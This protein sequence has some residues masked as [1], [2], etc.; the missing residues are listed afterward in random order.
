MK[1]LRRIAGVLIALAMLIPFSSDIKLMS[2][3]IIASAKS[4]DSSNSETTTPSSTEA[5]PAEDAKANFTF[6]DEFRAVTITPGKDF[7]KDPNQ[8]VQTTQAEIDK[9]ISNVNAY[10]MTSIIINTSY[11]NNAYFSSGAELN[12][13]EQAMKM[14]IDSAKKSLLFVYVNLNMNFVLNQLDK[15]ADLQSRVDYLTHIAHKFSREYFIDGIILDGYYSS[16]TISS[17]NSYVENGSGIGFEN[18]LL[19]NGAYVFG[20]VS[21]AIHKTDNKIPVGIC[22]SNAWA[23]SSENQTGSNTKDNFQALKDGFSDTV[24]YIKNGYADFIIVNAFGSLTDTNLPFKEFVEWWSKQAVE[25][26]V[27]LFVSH[28]NE[29]LCTSAQGWISEDQILKQLLAIEKLPNYKGSAFNS[30]SSLAANTVTTNA[31]IKYYDKQINVD[32]IFKELNINS[33]TKTVFTTYEPTVKFQGS[34]DS[35]F[36]VYFNNQP[37]KLNEAGNFYYEVPLNVGLNVFTIRNKATTATYKITRQVKVLQSIQPTGTL[38]VDGGN[39]INVSAIAYK[40]ANITATLNGTTIK[41]TQADGQVEGIDPNSNY[42]LFSGSFKAPK[43]QVNKDQNLGNIIIKGNYQG[44]S[45]GSATGANVIVNKLPEGSLPTTLIKITNP[46]GS[47]SYDA[48]SNYSEEIPKTRLPAGTYD[49]LL[50]TVTYSGTTFYVTQSGRRIEASDGVL[51]DGATFANNKIQFLGSS[52]ENY[53]TVLKFKLDKNSPFDIASN[54]CSFYS[55]SL[56]NYYV[57]YNATS[58]VITFDYLSTVLNNVS[59]PANSIFSS[60]SWSSSEDAYGKPQQKLTLNLKKAG[61]YSGVA[62]SYSAD[63]TLTLSFN[64]HPSGLQGAVIVIDPGH[65]V[66]AKDSGK[67]DPGAIGEVTEQTI[68]KEVSIVLENRLKAL[69][70]TVYR[71]PTE[72]NQIMTIT[73]ANYAKQYKPDIMLSIHC[74]SAVASAQGTE[75]YYFHPFSQPL[76]KYFTNNISGAL[77]NSNRGSKYNTYFVNLQQEFPSSLVELGF[78]TNHDEAMKLANPAYQ[79]SIADA[80][81]NGISQYLANN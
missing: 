23:N 39:T 62:P 42:T 77:Q 28:A 68:N 75:A 12:A 53:D 80:I 51:E 21:E 74:N 37:I 81:A 73:R 41:L 7:L 70:A 76:A 18:W 36:D 67:F 29:K 65:G 46:N 66:G 22:I 71:L 45:S 61:G 40:G 25:A 38:N 31:L 52:I 64:G 24:S 48:F 63:G 35:N 19:E 59:L 16:K 27:P 8:S 56:G 55:G 44:V 72:S 49:Y 17:Y 34:F 47:S 26:N 15:N 11:E 14:L 3:E 4:E 20:L 10:K 30:Y 78:V 60:A 9:I 43:G 6:P 79:N 13:Q 5:K 58:I 33:P 54:P 57:N 1:I 2:N 50:K 32:S 69:G